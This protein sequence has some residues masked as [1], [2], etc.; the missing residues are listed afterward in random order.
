LNNKQQI[1]FTPSGLKRKGKNG[2][3]LLKVAQDA[4]VALRSLC[5]GYGQCHQCWVEVSEGKH[6]KFGVEC[7]PENVSGVTTLERQLIA[8]NPI[9]KGKRLACQTCVKGD[10]VIDVPEESQEHKAY[11]SKKNA[12]Q[13][14]SLSSAISIFNCNLEE[15]TLDKNPSATENLLLQLKKQGVNAKVDFNLLGDLQGLISKTKGELTV[16]VRDNNK[17]VAIYPQ[18]ELQVI[19]AAIDIGS[20]TLALYVYDLQNGRLNYESSAMNP[21]IRYGEDLMSRVSYVMMNKDGEN[22]LAQAVRNKITE[23]LHNACE[24]LELQLDKLLEIVVVGNPI[25]H[26]IFFGISPVELGQAPFTVATRGWLDVD[27]QKLGLD[28][29]PN[30]R[31]S[32]LPLIAG[33]VGADTAAAYLSQMDIM[34]S[35][36]TLLVDIGT[37]AEIMLAKEGK[38][39]ATSSPTGPAFE[40]AEISSG[41]RA[42]YGAI[43]RVRIDKETLNIRY[44]VIGCDFWSDEPNFELANVKP[45]GICGSGIIEAIVSFAETG[46]IDQS[47]LF[48][49]SIASD[50]FSKSGNTVRFLLVDQGEQSIFIEQVDIRSI[51]LAKAAL[52]AGVS[53][54]M[55]YLHCTNF[56]Q[57]LLAGAFGAHL[58]ARYVALLDIIPTS[59]EDK[60]ISVGNAA[61]IG[62]S[63]ALL[64]VNKRKNIIDAVDNVVKIETATES[65]FQQYFVDA[66]KFS[67][68]PTKSQKANKNRR[69]RKP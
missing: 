7:K 53:I 64:D 62:A 15:S 44:K 19:G 52:S 36:T 8:D 33:H 42:T 56:D 61:G 40:G 29:Y 63:A 2:E 43:E 24:I 34:H 31:I 46:I 14:Y 28:L 6:S 69:R 55:D 66:M 58:D 65:K 39:Y 13:D 49:E 11:I 16:A 59:T 4:G 67:V 48:V 12:K 23:M 18:G 38:V 68:S 45:I 10:L 21:Q 5:G 60:I 57:I 30:T 35:Q 17:V 27:A 37:N 22:K 9:Y 3:T 47:G 20:T 51:Q 1:C 25:M 50:R 32:S 26:H 41:V 54:L